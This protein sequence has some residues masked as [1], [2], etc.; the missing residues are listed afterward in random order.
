M[1]TLLYSLF[2]DE[3]KYEQY[4]SGLRTI[5][6]PFATSLV[7]LFSFGNLLKTLQNLQTSRK[8]D[9]TWS[10]LSRTEISWKHA[11]AIS[12]DLLCPSSTETIRSPHW[13][14]LL[15]TNITGTSRSPSCNLK[16]MINMKRECFVAT[17]NFSIK[18][19][20]S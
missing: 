3:S 12:L 11:Q 10:I 4:V 14:I 1:K 17:K 20:M 6:I 5:S 19:E 7:D 18:W 8:T 13:S 9:K 15:P 16:K 2:I